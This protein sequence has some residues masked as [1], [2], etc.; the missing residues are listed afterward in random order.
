MPV[1]VSVELNPQG[2]RVWEVQNG[3]FALNDLVTLSGPKGALQG[4]VC[5]IRNITSGP[6][7]RPGVYLKIAITGGPVSSFANGGWD[8]YMVEK[9]TDSTVGT[10][11]PPCKEKFPAPLL[12]KTELQKMFDVAR[13]LIKEAAT[14]KKSDYVLQWF[15][16]QAFE[17]QVMARVNQRCGELHAGVESLTNMI[18]RVVKSETLGAIDNDDPLRG[19]GTCRIRLGRGFTYDRYSWGERV[20]TIVHELTHWFLDTIDAVT[21]GGV[22]AYGA[23]CLNLA[24]STSQAESQKALNNADNWAYYICQYRSSGDARDWSNFTEE[25]LRNR[26]PFVP[27]GYN[28]VS[29]LIAP[30]S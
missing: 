6:Q 16:K 21:S 20:G 5:D 18:F 12:R 23:E 22:D 25:E 11:I 10:I 30:D 9:C 27:G 29:E 26:K 4:R 2:F 1:T 19:G 8:D 15:G 17:K 13:D 14:I 3:T 24:R 7:S 28:V